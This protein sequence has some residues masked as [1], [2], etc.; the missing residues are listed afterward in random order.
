MIAKRL[1][2]LRLAITVFLALLFLAATVAH[3][4]DAQ[5]HNFSYGARHA[6]SSSGSSSKEWPNCKLL[7]QQLGSWEDSTTRSD[8]AIQMTTA[9]DVPAV[10]SA[11]L[12]FEAI[13]ASQALGP[14]PKQ[15][16][17]ITNLVFRI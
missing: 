2:R 5:S 14:P 11:L 17:F 15:P 16:L 4:C 1:K 7:R 10:I 6:H 9:F 12:Q 8:L 13:T 3:A